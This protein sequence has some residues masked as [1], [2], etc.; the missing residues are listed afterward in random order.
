M[1][2]GTGYGNGKTVSIRVDNYGKTATTYT[3]SHQP[4]LAELYNNDITQ[5]VHVQALKYP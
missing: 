3:L 1:M 5:Q 4:A 2:L